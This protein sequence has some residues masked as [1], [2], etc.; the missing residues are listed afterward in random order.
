VR[1]GVFSLLWGSVDRDSGILALCRFKAECDGGSLCNRC[2][3]CMALA[4]LAC[5]YPGAS[6]PRAVDAAVG[7]AGE[8]PRL[9]FVL[10]RGLGKADGGQLTFLMMASTCAWDSSVGL[11]ASLSRPTMMTVPRRL[12]CQP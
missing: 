10:L 3:A 9:A 6:C 11:V 12:S 5:G 8:E 2:G 4:D 1:I 7:L